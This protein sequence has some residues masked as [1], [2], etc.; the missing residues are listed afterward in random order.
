[1]TY[2]KD[3]V[4]KKLTRGDDR[5]FELWIKYPQE[6]PNDPLLYRDLTGSLISFTVKRERSNGK[7]VF[8]DP[9]VIRKTSDDTE[10]IE[11]LNQTVRANWGR[12]NV[13]V[14]ADDTKYLDPGIYL[15][16]VQVRLPTNMIC[17]VARGRILLQGDVTSAEDL[18]RP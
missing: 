11:V 14:R 5:I 8:K 1:M 17:T 7:E 12:A 2:V 6:T 9:V 3:S 15:Y 18:T 10:Q 16:D 4:D 13:L